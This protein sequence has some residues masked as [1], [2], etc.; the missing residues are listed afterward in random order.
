MYVIV[1]NVRF[2][3]DVDIGFLAGLIFAVYSHLGVPTWAIDCAL[4]A[5]IIYKHLNPQALVQ[6]EREHEDEE[7]EKLEQETQLQQEAQV[8]IKGD[9]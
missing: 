7:E 5:I 2:S 8:E 9:F 4:N 1:V 6:V 3:V